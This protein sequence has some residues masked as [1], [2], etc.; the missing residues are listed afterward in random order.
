MHY[1]C[2]V[3][4]LEGMNIEYRSGHSRDGRTFFQFDNVGDITP[5]RVNNAPMGSTLLVMDKGDGR[6]EI[7]SKV[8]IKLKQGSFQEGDLRAWRGRQRMMISAPDQVLGMVLTPPAAV[9]GPQ[10]EAHTAQDE[11][12]AAAPK[13]GW[14]ARLRDSSLKDSEGRPAWLNIAET[15]SSVLILTVL[16][17][18]MAALASIM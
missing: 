18:S 1:M 13:M 7:A 11:D 16:F 3:K 14:L 9:C 12:P 6:V 15:A 10:C 5:W 2:V 8:P 4:P 17:F